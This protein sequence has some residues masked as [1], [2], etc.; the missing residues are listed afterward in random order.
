MKHI[1]DLFAKYRETLQPPQAS[2]ERVVRLAIATVTKISVTEHMVTYKVSE[3]AVYLTAPSV[4]KSE[5]KRKELEIL[6]EIEKE[7]GKQKT[8]VRIS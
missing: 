4:I 5:I 7:L 6:K 3:R 1:S 8:P 2:V